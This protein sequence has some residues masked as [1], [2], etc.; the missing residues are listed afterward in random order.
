MTDDCAYALVA[1]D[2][3]IGSPADESANFRAASKGDRVS[4]TDISLLSFA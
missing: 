4:D 3:V 2:L 1:Y